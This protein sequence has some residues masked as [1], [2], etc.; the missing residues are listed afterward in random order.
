MFCSFKAI[1]EVKLIPLRQNVPLLVCYGMKIYLLRHGQTFC[2]VQ[3]RLAG[4]KNTILTK[5]GY[6]QAQQA[7]EK[8]KDIKFD[9]I[10]VSTTTRT[11]QTFSPFKGVPAQFVDDIKEL[12]VGIYEGQPYDTFRDAARE[13][14]QG[15]MEYVPPQGESIKEFQGRIVKFLQQCK[16]NHRNENILW[17]THHGVISYL[18]LLMIKRIKDAKYLEVDNC[19][20]T[21]VDYN[22]NTMDNIVV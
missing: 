4:D 19:S 21:I 11:I 8:L 1:F 9:Q 14:E 17:V 20:V 15:L 6:H 12:D 16:E 22:S 18:V 13:S 2:N 7:Y 5:K 10:Y 3:R